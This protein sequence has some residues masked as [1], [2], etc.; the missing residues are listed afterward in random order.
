MKVRLTEATT[1]VATFIIGFFLMTADALAIPPQD[2]LL[3]SRD[4]TVLVATTGS[5]EFPRAGGYGSGVLLD[6]QGTILTNYHVIHRA[7][8]LKI[9]FQC[10]TQILLD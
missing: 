7:S 10:H 5:E 2:I 1:L 6:A 4:A 8:E 3:K 9:W